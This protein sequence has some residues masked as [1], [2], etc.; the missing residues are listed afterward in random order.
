[1]KLCDGCDVRGNWEHRCHGEPCPCE[2]CRE[3]DRL[4][5]PLSDS[6]GGRQ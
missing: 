3:A 6:P 1:M 4:F 2:E 5:G